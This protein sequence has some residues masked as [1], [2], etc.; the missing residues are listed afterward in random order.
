VELDDALFFEDEE[1]EL[2]MT[3]TKPWYEQVDAVNATFPKMGNGPL[4]DNSVKARLS[5]LQWLATQGLNLPPGVE[6]IL[7][8]G[9]TDL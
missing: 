2:T 8:L 9:A 6:R 4:D 1:E 3:P 7:V 5:G